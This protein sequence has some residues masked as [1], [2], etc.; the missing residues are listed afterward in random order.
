[1]TAAAPNFFDAFASYLR[2]GQNA[3]AQGRFTDALEFYDLAILALSSES[4][5]NPPVRHARGIAWM[6]R[7][8]AL[9][10]N[11]LSADLIEATRAYDSALQEFESLPHESAP[12]LRNHLGAAWLNRGH[13]LLASGDVTGA[14]VSFE[15]AANLLES[16]PLEKDVSY[17]L[18]LAGARTNLAHVLIPTNPERAR[19]L[20]QASLAL[21]ADREHEHL[22]L[23]EMSLRA[24]RALVMALGEILRRGTGVPS[25]FPDG[26]GHDTP[27]AQTNLANEAT[28]AVDD[29]LALAREL[30][31]RGVSQLRPLALRLFRLGAQLYRLHQ[32]H[33]L[34]EF[35]QDNLTSPA[36]A[37]DPNFRATATEALDLAMAEVQ[38][39]RKLVVGDASA[40]RLVETARSLRSAQ[41]L[42]S[43]L[44]LHPSTSAV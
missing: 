21:L 13:S 20:A 42:L 19:V 1:M 12:P 9:Q 38:R 5:G 22:A 16:L 8:N 37:A 39:P 28:D 32:P 43:R 15:R 10:K 26:D 4:A 29:G 30:E 33:F 3:E 6:N 41:E 14:A 24:R 18:N 36:F 23:S 27:A 34:A 25:V 11:G 2:E 17:R 44:T 31:A 40:E 7:G 35:V